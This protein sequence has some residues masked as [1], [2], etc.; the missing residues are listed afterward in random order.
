MELTS[1]LAAFGLSSAAGIN[2]YKPLLTIALLARYTSIIALEEPLSIL[3]NGWIIITLT[4]LLLIELTVD[5]IP[6]VDHMNDI[7]QT[8]IRP[9]AGAIVFAIGSGAIGMAH[10]ILAVI[11][12]L[13]LAGGIHTAKSVVRVKSTVLTVGLANW[14]ISL[15]EDVLAFIAILVAIFFLW[16]AGM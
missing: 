7:I 9:I 2:A 13:I 11:A 14:A 15:T 16:L 12:G 8:V 5:K 3:T 10:P 1:L 4:V 6:L